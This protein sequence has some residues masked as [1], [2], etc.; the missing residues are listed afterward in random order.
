MQNLPHEVARTNVGKFYKY[1]SPD[2]QG[3]RL[4]A[5]VIIRGPAVVIEATDDVALVTCDVTQ[6]QGKDH[7]R[8]VEALFPILQ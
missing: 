8:F 4:D 5:Y 6:I 3:R 7:L 1:R 2:R